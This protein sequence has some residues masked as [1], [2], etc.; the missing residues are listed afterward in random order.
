MGLSLHGP[1]ICTVQ[2]DLCNICSSVLAK[3][4]T[5]CCSTYHNNFVVQ[6]GER[7]YYHGILQYL[8]VGEHQFVEDK[9]ARS[10]INQMLVAWYAIT[11]LTLTNAIE[12]FIQGFCIQ[13]SKIIFNVLR[14]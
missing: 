1:L 7:T 3:T 12:H 6:D 9:V 14:K 5:V 4:M 13:C 2:V 11:L 8:Q 10:W